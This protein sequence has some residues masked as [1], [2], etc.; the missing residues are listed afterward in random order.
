MTEAVRLAKRVVELTGCS[1]SEAEL[2]V[3]GGW[4][5]VDGVVI[6]EPQHKVAEETVALL[7]GALL[8]RVLSKRFGLARSL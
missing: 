7:P 1:R 4:V 8:D 3:Q 6:E 5:T 2:Y